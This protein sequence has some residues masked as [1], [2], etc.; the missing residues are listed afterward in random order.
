[1]RFSILIPV[2]DDLKNLLACLRE[3]GRQDL[4]DSEVL[5]CDDGSQPPLAAADLEVT[6]VPVRLFRMEGRGPAAAR[7]F[8]ARKAGGK[9]LFFLD[10]DTQP[11]PDMLACA[12]RIIARSPGLEAFFG[13]YDDAP[14]HASLIS[15]YR[16]LLHH[17][18]HQ[19]FGGGRVSSFWC[20]CGVILRD[21]YLRYGGLSESYQRPSIEDIELGLRLSLQGIQIR[22]FPEL[23]V[24]HLKRWTF[25]TWVYTDLCRRGVPWVRLMRSSSKWVNELNF[26]WMQRVGALAALLLAALL[27]AAPLRPWLAALAPAPLALFV[28]VHYGFLHL[29][30][31]KRGAATAAAVVP[32]HLVYALVCVLSVAIGMFGPRIKLRPDGQPD[33]LSSHL[34]RG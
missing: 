30:A 33:L 22:I 4:A 27:A 1:M 9:Y 26:S 20:G 15:F 25:A 6:G 11:L 13:S 8:L 23:Q 16:N 7:N 17:Y 3:L 29:V 19:Q 34:S 21:L 5:I 14:Y 28:Y 12:R 32:L 18:T 2:R 10:A 31:A 24:K